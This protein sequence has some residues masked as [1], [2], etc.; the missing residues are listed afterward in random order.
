MQ[1]GQLAAKAG[2]NV[3]TIRFYER[4]R[5]LPEPPRNPSGY[6]S[7]GQS[8]LE[9]IRFIKQSQELG[10]TLKE[11]QQLMK[12]HQSVTAMPDSSK[13]P[14]EWRDIGQITRAR[15]DHLEQKLRLLRAMRMQLRA[16]L[17]RL[18]T[19]NSH[20]CPASSVPFRSRR[21]F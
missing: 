10:F 20:A 3:Q 6:R 11:I 15:L 7:Y 5:I 17:H 19:A 2:V 13:R 9:D 16:M 14:R 8:D 21:K 12:L 18:E 1:I 4:E